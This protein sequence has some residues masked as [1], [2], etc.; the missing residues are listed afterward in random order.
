MKN[1]NFYFIISFTILLV[2]FSSGC[3]EKQLSEEINGQARE[4]TVAA[5]S[6]LTLAF[7]EV[8]K[9]FEEETNSKITFSFGSTGQ[10]A[11]QI[12]HGAPFDIFAAANIDFVDN[13][14]EKNLII[15]DT[16]TTYAFGRIGV[17]TIPDSTIEIET[18]EDLLKPEVVKIAIANPEHA[19]YGLAAKQALET[20]GLWD[21]V[22]HKL[23]FGRNISETLT[24]IET[25][26]AEVGIIA[27]S[28]YKEGEVNFHLIDDALHAPLEQ[29]IAVINRTNEVDLA[30]QFI[31]FIKGPIGKPIMENYG[32]IVP[33]DK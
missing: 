19:P 27:L 15:P 31:D 17:T 22:E 23:V 32:F 9:L 5:A 13:L 28:L 11:D 24:F 20:A 8:G 6:D 7:T 21:Q 25:K 4:L 3:N 30:I 1:I 18:L 2:L 33:E 26:N 29:S 12:E 14:R 10:L 16:Q